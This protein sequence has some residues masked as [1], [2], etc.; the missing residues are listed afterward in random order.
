MSDDIK[1]YLEDWIKRYEFLGFG[2][3]LHRFVL[4]H[5]H[6][7]IPQKR[8]K[9]YRKRADK[10][11][12]RNSTE[13]VLFR[14]TSLTYVEGMA[15]NN[16]LGMPIHHAWMEDA[17]RNVIDLTWRDPADCMYYGVPFDYGRLRELS[18]RFKVYGLLDLGWGVNADL[19]LE[20]D[21]GL[22]AEVEAVESRPPKME[23]VLKNI[24]ANR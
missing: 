22:A 10:M 12:F 13:H 7:G 4:K 9:G 17:Q 8:P 20:M 2:A 15:I 3:M 1:T 24:D 18:L 5:G 16:K 23:E 14:D 21:P 11:C 6:A 19:M